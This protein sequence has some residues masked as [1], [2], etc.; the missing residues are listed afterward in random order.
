ME[1]EV[2]SPEQLKA[3][4]ALTA[5]SQA[6]LAEA[7]KVS[8]S[9][10]ADFER[11][12]RDPMPNNALAMR[13]VLEAKG[14]RFIAGGVVERTL[15][16]A[17]S[18]LA[19]PGA[20]M[21]WVNATHL[22]QWGETR[23]G[24][25]GMP[26]LIARLIYAAHGPAAVIEFPADESIQQAGLDG[27]CVVAAGDAFV[28][29]GRSAWELGCQREGVRGKAQR[30][31]DKR[32]KVMAADGP[33]EDTFVFVTPQ[34][35][36]AKEAWLKE[37]RSDKAFADV[38]VVDA[39][40]LVH[41]IEQY[42]A[43]ALWLAARIAKRPAGLRNLEETWEE[44]S[45]AT[46][47]P[48][49]PD[50]VL[51]GRDED[52]TA[53]MAWIQDQPRLM[54]IQAEAP[55]EGMAFLY[56]AI[57]ALPDAYR[58][59]YWSRCVV[60]DD[61]RTAR[62][63]VGVASQLYVVLVDPETGL[64][65]RLVADGHH[66]LA[67]YGAQTASGGVR[68][69]ARPLPHELEAALKRAG[70]GDQVAHQAARGAGR[71]ITVLRRLMPAAPVQGAQWA[72]APS[73]A[74][75]AA[76]LAGGWWEA[77]DADRRILETLVGGQSYSAIEAEL[78]PLARFGGPLA[79]S[80][81]YWRVVSL[82]DLWAQVAP[83]L[84]S[85]QIDRF[86]QVFHDVFS[87]TD[88]AYDGADPGD[89]AE[90]DRQ[91]KARASGVLR[92][93]L[94][95][96][97]IALGVYPD[98]AGLVSNAPSRA[99]RAVARLLGEA[100]E[101]VWWSLSRDF[102]R[103]AE[104][105]PKSFLAALD[106]ALDG[107]APAMVLFRADEGMLAP[108]E[109]LAEVLWALQIL[110][111]SPDYLSRAALL[112]ARL[113]S[114]DA[115]DRRGGNRPASELRE[116]FV[117]WT[118]QTYATPSQRLQ[119]IDA[120]LKRYPA[121]GWNL[122]VA[123]APSLHDSADV[124]PHP[125]WRDFTV[126][127]P[128]VITWESL[129]RAVAEIGRR[130]LTH[131]E[132]DGER[133]CQ[134][135]EMWA[136]FPPEWR[137]EANGALLDQ[138]KG[139][140]DADEIE[141]MRKALRDL[142]ETHR[143][144]AEAAWALPM[145]ELAGV[146]TALAVLPAESHVDRLRRVFQRA[147]R[148]GQDPN[149]RE[150]WTREQ[151]DAVNTLLTH[152]MPN[153]LLP[154][155]DAVDF[156][157]EL[158]YAIGRSRATEAGK[159][160]LLKAFLT[161]EGPRRAEVGTG[162]LWALREG[163]GAEALERLW[164]LEIDQDWGAV[165]ELRTVLAFEPAPEIWSKI[166]ARSPQIAADYWRMIGAFRLP[167]EHAGEVVVEL[168]A[169]GRAHDAVA[170]LDRHDGAL[171][172]ADL[173][174]DTLRAAAGQ[175]GP[176]GGNDATMFSFH[177]GNHLKRLDADPQVMEEQ[178]VGL[179]WTYF[180]VLQY[181]ERP[182]RTLQA[183][184]ARRPEFFVELLFLIFLP[185]NAPA[186]E[187]MADEDRERIKAM[188]SQAYG[189]LREWSRVPGSDDAGA[190]DGAVLEAWVKTARKLCAE[191]DRADIGDQKIG[192]ILSAAVAAPGQPWPPEPIRE[193]IEFARSRHLETGFE[194]GA[195]NRRGVTVRAAFDGGDQE[196]SLAD[197]YRADAEALRFDWSRTAAC[198]DRMADAYIADAARMDQMAEQ[199]TW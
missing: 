186:P 1:T 36:A 39:D 128:E 2:L 67:I 126:G 170:W 5:M 29:S 143:E 79:R 23:D 167:F 24:Q 99:D 89:W 131:A 47:T 30:D 14:L 156:H 173:V 180:K 3:A 40:I 148:M 11:G 70:A 185:A 135:L 41:W 63:L 45:R 20:L 188:A 61:D 4:R 100:D 92:R 125:E 56:A 149:W 16:P 197:R 37:R 192:E 12:A 177:L 140:N 44:W 81:D 127:E 176:R 62:D 26:E 74:L 150:T 76:M 15:L 55:E 82:R 133:W 52:A 38:R 164:A 142:L 194:I 86:E 107:A 171:A 58:R 172:P 108:V 87:Q 19:R 141:T 196:R 147:R 132:G 35:F 111:R 84:T 94:A 144:Y 72:K 110:A 114:L 130:L 85:G 191:G 78:A 122:L 27:T 160:G 139:L 43:V 13:D 49:G 184:L 115:P 153:D 106:S 6:Q 181:S 31:Y 145:S 8:P 57:A 25:E 46:L 151:L 137:T 193:V 90:Q 138:V 60:A 154:F 9:T 101:K 120:I 18:R 105:S 118:P 73:P 32:R 34:R 117:T 103:L 195:F 91:A 146:E 182:A 157:S 179:E 83:N 163:G 121:V 174:I 168:I 119:V 189:V 68:Q 50:I 98:R 53:V 51:T 88:P 152:G 198:L 33:S 112:L 48:V 199:R 169:A 136:N 134:L 102:R 155:A 109:Y 65:Q 123:L 64:V 159:V 104:A 113:A 166:A 183:A 77:S 116:I 75:V 10:V 96:A 158:G 175:S 66:V 165:A 7:A 54:A 71:S 93:G 95:E 42:P 59:Y 162:M 178:I 21:R 22:A 190:I 69:L 97:M 17:P 80:G 161:S 124:A 28:P 187:A 129:G